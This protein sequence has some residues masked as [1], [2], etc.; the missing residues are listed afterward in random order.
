ME[1][2][3]PSSNGAVVTFKTRMDAEKAIQTMSQNRFKENCQLNYSWFDE[4]LTKSLNKSEM[5]EALNASPS[6][7]VRAPRAVS[8]CLHAPPTAHFSYNHC[9]DSPGPAGEHSSD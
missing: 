2:I 9:S 3:E 1:V 4:N 6:Q 5:S 8:E 7:S